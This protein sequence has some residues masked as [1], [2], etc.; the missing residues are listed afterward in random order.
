MPFESALAFLSPGSEWTLAIPIFSCND[1]TFST[2]SAPGRI[3]LRKRKRDT[4]ERVMSERCGPK[5]RNNAGHGS[6]NCLLSCRRSDPSR[7]DK[8]QYPQSTGFGHARTGAREI[9]PTGRT[10]RSTVPPPPR[11]WSP[12]TALH[13]M[14]PTIFYV[15]DAAPRARALPK[16]SGSPCTGAFHDDD[17][18]PSGKG[19][20]K[21]RGISS[22]ALMFRQSVALPMPA[23]HRQET[24][25]RRPWPCFRSRCS[26]TRAFPCP[27]A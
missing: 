22:T 11:A 1:W 9:S 7:P 23:W 2:G 18:A 6:D 17:A 10:R 24:A 26:D 15:R 3:C 21:R 13:Q 5:A 20:K 8:R 25:S 4:R 27:S 12:L 14:R 16:R 19:M